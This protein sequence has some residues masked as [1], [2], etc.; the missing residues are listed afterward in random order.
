[1]AENRNGA[2]ELI[3][4]L[5]LGAAAGFL[6]GVLLAPAPGRTTREQWRERT[7]ES[8]GRAAGTI[9]SVGETVGQAST[10]LNEAK[11]QVQVG[12]ETA[13]HWVDQAGVAASKGVERF[14]SRDQG[15][16]DS[17]APGAPDTANPLH[18]GPVGS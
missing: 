17:E 11:E 7:S 10:W 4:G 8:L 3:A 12:Y 6:A 1:M 14:R 13:Q 15:E 16:L 9:G 2:I 5:I 18:D